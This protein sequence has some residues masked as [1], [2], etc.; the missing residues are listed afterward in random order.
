MIIC[1]WGDVPA[2]CGAYPASDGTIASILGIDSDAVLLPNVQWV[3]DAFS[4]L[5]LVSLHIHTWTADIRSRTSKNY[6]RTI[7]KVNKT[8]T[9]Y[10]YDR[11]SQGNMDK[12]WDKE[13]YTD[14]IHTTAG[15]GRKDGY[16][17]NLDTLQPHKSHPLSLFQQGD[18]VG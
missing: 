10:G 5:T 11:V 8:Y 17:S 4:D 18:K 7:T 15:E 14:I 2:W 6:D 1:S 13:Q 3:V 12:K 16:I 9:I